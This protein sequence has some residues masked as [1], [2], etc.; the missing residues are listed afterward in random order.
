MSKKNIELS[1][2]KIIDDLNGTD[3]VLFAPRSWSPDDLKE[4]CNNMYID[5]T[6]EVLPLEKSVAEFLTKE[7]F[8]I[9]HQTGLYN[10]QKKL[11][12]TLA[13]AR[14]IK[15]KRFSSNF[16]EGKDKYLISD[17]SLEIP[18]SKNYIQARVVHPGSQVDFPGFKRFIG[19]VPK[20]CNG[21]LYFADKDFSHKILHRVTNKTNSSDEIDRYRSPINENCSLNLIKY[22]VSSEDKEFYFQL[23]HPNLGRRVGATIRLDYQQV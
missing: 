17:I 13:K 5:F 15:I 4:V 10:L 11:W 9:Q 3:E 22:T 21:L 16:F 20:R 8:F 14:T 12:G 7:F 19:M 6:D 2:K 18:G 23:S 1:I